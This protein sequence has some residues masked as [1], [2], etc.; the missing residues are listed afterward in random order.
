MNLIEKGYNMDY[1]DL[2]DE[3]NIVFRRFE[4]E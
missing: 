4:N 3:N 2:I 1:L